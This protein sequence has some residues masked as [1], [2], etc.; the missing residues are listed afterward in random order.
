M[1]LTGTSTATTCEV[2]SKVGFWAAR[3]AASSSSGS[4]SE[5]R[6]GKRLR[7]TSSA[8][9]AA[10]LNN[11]VHSMVL[12]EEGS[13]QLRGGGADGGRSSRNG[14]CRRG[15]TRFCSLPQHAGVL[16]GVLVG[17]VQLQ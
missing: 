10:S 9:I 7:T 16:E 13:V 14:E 8:L 11:S 15:G 6:R 5:R 1:T 3:G 4:S 17:G 2:T 12:P